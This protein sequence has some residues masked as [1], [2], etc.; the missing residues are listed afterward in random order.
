MRKE[1]WEHSVSFLPFSTWLVLPNGT[2]SPLS[3]IRQQS[4]TA[5]NSVNPGRICR[6][7]FTIPFTVASLLFRASPIDPALRPT[8]PSASQSH[9]LKYNNTTSS[10]DSPSA[11]RQST[12][13][14]VASASSASSQ[15]F[16]A[17]PEFGSLDKSPDSSD[18]NGSSFPGSLGPSLSGLSALASVASAPTSNLRYVLG[19]V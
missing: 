10:I 9:D 8:S 17:L 2:D 18:S 6:G 1:N 14:A 12:T 7:F 16:G 11:S 3:R 13:D 19:V 4:R 15:Y 5:L